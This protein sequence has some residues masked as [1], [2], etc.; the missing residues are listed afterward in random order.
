M[1]EFPLLPVQSYPV[2][3][4]P[5][6]QL[7]SRMLQSCEKFVCIKRLQSRRMLWKNRKNPFSPK[8]SLVILLTVPHT[9]SWYQFG[10]FSFGSTNNSLTDTLSIFSSLFCLICIVN[11]RRNFVLV[12]YWSQS[13]KMLTV[14]I[15]WR[16]RWKESYNDDRERYVQKCMQ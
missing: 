9:S 11:V 16:Y 10:E 15:Q 3:L 14:K 4:Q 13:F 7:W 12:N 1:I 6:C 5:G 8:I 2:P